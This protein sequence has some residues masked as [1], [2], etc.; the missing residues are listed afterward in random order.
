MTG[1]IPHV[2]YFDPNRMEPCPITRRFCGDF[3]C[4]GGC[5]LRR[6]AANGESLVYGQDLDDPDYLR[7]MARLSDEQAGPP[8][9]EHSDRVRAIADGV[10]R[11]RRQV[12]ILSSALRDAHETLPSGEWSETK[13]RMWEAL[14]KSGLAEI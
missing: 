6:R 13:A 7:E 4:L 2:P 11:L 3:D 12:A 14:V 8:V 5:R 9:K 1:D 10:G